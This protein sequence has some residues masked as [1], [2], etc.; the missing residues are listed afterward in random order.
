MPS[1]AP[2]QPAW[3]APITAPSRSTINT[4]AVGRRDGKPSAFG[5]D[6]PVSAGQLRAV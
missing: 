6:Q 5:C 3:Q 2:R 1:A 4:A